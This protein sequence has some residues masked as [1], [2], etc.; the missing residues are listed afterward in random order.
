MKQEYNRNGEWRAKGAAV[1][2]ASPLGSRCAVRMLLGVAFVTLHASLFT[3][4]ADWSDHYEDGPAAGQGLTVMQLLEQDNQTA[5]FAGLV[6]QSG[7]ADLLASS[8]ALTVFAPAQSDN[9]GD[10]RRMVANHIALHIYPTSTPQTVGV[11]MLNG[12]IYSFDAHGGFAGSSIVR[13]NQKADNGLVH[14]LQTP[15]PY[16]NNLYEHIEMRPELSELYGFIHQFDE[17]RFDVDNSVEV[18]IDELGRPV[19]DSVFV[20]YNRLLEDPVYGLGSIARE[21]SAFTMLLPTNDAWRQAY[22]R[23]APSFRVFDADEAVADSLQDVRTRLAIVSDLIYRAGI[24]D[25]SPSDSAVSTTGSIIH[26]PA[27][28]LAGTTRLPASNGTAYLCPQLNYDSRET[29]NKPILVEA[30]QQNGRTYNN[31]LTSVF[32]RSVT[33]SSLIEG[34]GGEAYIEVMPISTSTNPTVIFDI[35]NLLAGTYN[36]YCVFLPATVEGPTDDLDSTKVNFTLTYMNANGR[37]A[38]KRPSTAEARDLITSG[39][40]VTRMLALGNVEIPVSNTTDRLWLMDSANDPTALPTTT[41]LTIT[42]NVTA[43]EFSSGTYARS[44]RLD[45]IIFEPAIVPD[46]SPSGSIESQIKKK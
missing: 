34:I 37:S 16:V 8:Q 24:P 11:E 6:R 5:G 36:I 1:P 13:A 23:I 45:R 3:S 19:Y 44:F 21:D 40:E 9:D 2:K 31:T 26:H 41:T 29:W 33:A 27:Q 22:E 7:Y 25:A 38:T 12:K 46:A 17:V 43:R 14:S 39:A 20:S 10:V 30:E 28:L 35:P 15:I 32:Q 42:T 4:C 18:D